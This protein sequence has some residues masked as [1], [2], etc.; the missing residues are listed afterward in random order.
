[1]LGGVDQGVAGFATALTRLLRSQGDDPEMHLTGDTA[2]VTQTTWRVMAGREQMSPAIFDAWNELWMG[3]ALTH[4][5]FMR[6][7]LISRR[8][9]GD[10]VWAWKIQEGR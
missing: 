6:V 10:P 3:A 1:M 8:D 2:I 5:R 7:S 4:D 9:A